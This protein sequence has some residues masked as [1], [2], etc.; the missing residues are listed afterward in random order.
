MV[1]E[2]LAIKYYGY[3]PYYR[4]TRTGRVETL[5]FRIR[6]PDG[7]TRTDPDEWSLDP[8]VLNVAGYI[9]T[10]ITQDD[11]DYKKPTLE[12]LKQQKLQKLENYWDYK[13]GE[14]WSSPE[15]WKLGLTIN[16]VT[17]LTGAFLLLKEGVN[18]NLT[19]STTIIDMDNVAHTIDLQTMT[20]LMLSYGQYRA[21]L[22]NEYSSIKNQIS[23]AIDENQLDAIIIG[24]NNGGA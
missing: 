18:L 14:G 7:S 2:D 13:I 15:G 12:N 21:N 20:M 10:N 24:E 5:P 23:E 19:S 9:E 4:N 3:P 16:D 22:S 11:I 1:D 6:M 8:S 17:L